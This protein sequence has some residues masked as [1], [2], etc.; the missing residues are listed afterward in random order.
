MVEI[1]LFH[2]L[3]SSLSQFY[4]IS[5]IEYVGFNHGDVMSNKLKHLLIALGL[6]TLASSCGVEEFASKKNK[7]T[8]STNPIVTSSQVACS[9]F[10]YIKPKVDFLF[11]WDNSSSAI[12]INDQ[13]RAALNQTIDLIST[14]FD[15]HIVLAPLVLPQGASVNSYAGLIVSDTPLDQ[16][17]TKAKNMRIDRSSAQAHLSS[18]TS[19]SVGSAEYGAQRAIDVLNNNTTTGVLNEAFRRE[20]HTVVVLMSTEDDDSAT[21]NLSSYVANR[22]SQLNSIKNNLNSQQLRFFSIVRKDICNENFA[23]MSPTPYNLG[24]RQVSE[25]NFFAQSPTPADPKGDRDSFNLCAISDFTRVF[26]DINNSILDAILSHKY[27]YWPVAQAGANIDPDEIIVRK[28]GNLIPRLNEPVSPGANGF[29]FTYNASPGCTNTRYEPTSGEPFCGHV[30]RLYGNAEV[31]YPECMSVTTQTAKEWYGYV[32]LQSKPLES[33]IQLKINGVPVA[34]CGAC[35]GS[36]NGYRLMKTGS[37]PQYQANRN[38]RIT[39]PSN[40]AP[41]TPG[42]IKSGYFLELFGTAIYSNGESVEVIYDPSGT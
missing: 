14:R 23:P 20:A 10:T 16:L 33:S 11:L 39:S 3:D 21:N 42:I 22:V 7:D 32:H 8:L 19:F 9:N 15:Y 12:F 17:T 30:I 2:P 29:S 1:S 41:M 40:K 25:Q 6:L 18:F 4:P 27:N 5:P 38:L 34:N 36:A 35:S 31:V 37:E 24:Y 13:T 26:D 28:D